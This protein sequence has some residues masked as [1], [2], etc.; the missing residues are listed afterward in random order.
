[1][2]RNIFYTILLLIISL[3][4]FG[5]N[6]H[7]IAEKGVIDFRNWN[8]AEEGNVKLK[9]EW[10]LYWQKL[11]TPADFVDQVHSADA[12]IQTPGNWNGLNVNNTLLP[13]TGYATMRLVFF[14]NNDNQDDISILIPEV[15]TAYKLWINGNL[16]TEVGTVGTNQT[17]TTPKVR[18]TLNSI[19]LAGERNEIIIQIANFSHRN[20]CF[21]AAPIIGKTEQVVKTFTWKIVYDIFFFAIVLIMAFYHLGLFIM[22]RKNTAALSF[23][24]MSIILAF[25]FVFTDSYPIDFL[26]PGI[27]WNFTYIIS[28]L[29]FYLM[30][31]LFVWYLNETFKEKKYK[32]IFYIIYIFTGLFLLTLILPTYTFSKLLVFYQIF[33]LLA[34]S[35]SIF[36]LIRYLVQKRE[37]AFI[38]FVSTVLLFLT[39]I[40]DI[41][42]YQNI[43]QTA[44]LMPL[45][46]F[47]MVLGQSLTLARI[48][49]K[50]F[51]KN[52]KLTAELD[53]H[54]KHLQELVD[55]RTREITNQKQDILQKNEELM[56]Q[57]EELQVQKDEIIK[58]KELLEDKNKF[59]TDSIRYA[60]TIQKAV[61]PVNE[62][63]KKYFNSF[64]IYM[65]KN[66][67][68]GDFYWFSDASKKYVF[69][70]VGDCTGHGV[71]GAFLSLI[72]M[73][74]LN[75]IV[76]EEQI[77]DP[78]QIITKLN[79][80]FNKFLN[81]GSNENR[82][83]ME[84]GILR[85]EKENLSKCVYSAA[86]T[87]IFIYNRKDREITRYR[88][89]RK[90]IGFL[91]SAHAKKIDF[92]NKEFT[93]T[94]ANTIYCSTDGY[95]DQNNHE[96]KRFGTKA[97]TDMLI[98]VAEL[99]MQQQKI[100]IIRRFEEFQQAENQRDDVT[101]IGI[102][103]KF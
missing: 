59:V 103:P 84:F 56:V 89:T 88:G 3:N 42:Y 13:D 93:I 66:I 79:E 52:E 102:S 92:E 21:D 73:Y 78:K 99:P 81:R 82:D 25:R 62:S 19:K 51:V 45:G 14:A 31:P 46:V 5:Q 87:N 40:N 29:T 100:S 37:G 9:G 2:T 47:I 44:T 30:I 7:P 43:I 1:M 72:G 4:L 12:Y 101:V 22:R 35:F 27:S 67:V 48:F 86:K 58:Q 95:V 74:L 28:Y 57:K 83:G 6:S 17:N 85:F 8:F 54:N 91:E 15:L 55:E 41:L 63:I 36:L 71:P 39:G 77:E 18:L 69:I 65:P 11:Y 10:E 68:S 53:F 32:I 94:A 60:S 76:I 26:F 24:I 23:A 96:R 49:T 61:L 70:G 16:V 38:L 20:S 80:L 90:S 50:A 75:T 98:Q 34:I 33:T 64:F 97:F